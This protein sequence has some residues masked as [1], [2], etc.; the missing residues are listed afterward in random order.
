[1][2]KFQPAK[3]GR[4]RIEE[5]DKSFEKTKPWL[6]LKMSRRTWYKRRREQKELEAE[7]AKGG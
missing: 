1:M 7:K 3:K 2:I 4:R 6:K 5:Q